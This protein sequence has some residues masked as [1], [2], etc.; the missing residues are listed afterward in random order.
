[1]GNRSQQEIDQLKRIIA[2]LRHQ[3]EYDVV[4][5]LLNSQGLRKQALGVAKPDG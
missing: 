3:V 4:T 1:M 2:E 5:G